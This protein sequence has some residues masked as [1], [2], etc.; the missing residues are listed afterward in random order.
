MIELIKL[1]FNNKLYF[2]SLLPNCSLYVWESRLCVYRINYL[3]WG[4]LFSITESL[5]YIEMFFYNMMHWYQLKVLTQIKLNQFI[6]CLGTIYLTFSYYFH[7]MIASG[8]N[9]LNDIL[10]L[11]ID[12]GQHYLKGTNKAF[13]L[14]FMHKIHCQ[15]TLL[16][17]LINKL[18]SGFELLFIYPLWNAVKIWPMKRIVSGIL[19]NLSKI[20]FL[21]CY[22]KRKNRQQT[23]EKKTLWRNIPTEKSQHKMRN[24]KSIE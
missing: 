20:S 13:T 12:I 4:N 5:N 21:L 24:L 19:K 11:K 17:K 8:I 1:W 7:Y 14:Y 22:R 16:V 2:C 3:K 6:K 15:Q 23:K 9:W 18:C 10:N